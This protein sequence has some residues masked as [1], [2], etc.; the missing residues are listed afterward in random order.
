MTSTTTKFMVHCLSV[1]H[2]CRD[3]FQLRIGPAAIHTAGASYELVA[4]IEAGHGTADNAPGDDSPGRSTVEVM[5]E[6]LPAV[7]AELQRIYDEGKDAT[8]FPPGWP[9]NH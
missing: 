1:G 4:V 7:I 5:L 6:D 8:D 9:I 2:G 3:C